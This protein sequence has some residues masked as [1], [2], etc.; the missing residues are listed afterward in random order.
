MNF[1]YVESLIVNRVRLV[2]CIDYSI[3]RDLLIQEKVL[4]NNLIE[5]IDS[6][7]L[8]AAQIRE[9]LDILPRRPDDTF[10]SFLECLRLSEQKHIVDFLQESLNTIFEKN[11]SN[12]RV[13]EI[14][15]IT[16]CLSNM[17]ITNRG[18][19]VCQPSSNPGEQQIDLSE[20]SIP[21][22]P[23]VA[24]SHDEY[25]QISNDLSRYEMSS[26]PRGLFLI[27][28]ND[29]YKEPIPDRLGSK[30]DAAD[31]KALF[32]DLGFS[33]QLKP[34]LSASAMKSEL[35]AFSQLTYVTDCIAVA[36]LCHGQNHNML[37]GVDG[38]LVALEDILGYFNVPHLIDKPKLFI[39]Q[40]CRSN[41]TPDTRINPVKRSDVVIAYST[42]P[43]EV[44]FRDPLTGTIFI[45]EIISVFRQYSNYMSV[46]NMLIKV[47]ANMTAKYPDLSQYPT[48]EF[49]LNKEWYLK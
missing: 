17:R 26:N 29:S 45:Q 28:N 37:V 27:I 42:S 40:A 43:G 46:I 35:K 9:L 49:A 3:I 21:S 7:G 10:V 25:E 11:Q 36:I 19:P 23:T 22:T 41:I 1:V 8:R 5:I 38:N 18:H 39:I 6:K 32:L 47:R 14:E 4:P 13:Q 34:N 24:L 12:L 15:S 20:N 16:K 33:C 48:N 31:L 30:K 2:K 44:S